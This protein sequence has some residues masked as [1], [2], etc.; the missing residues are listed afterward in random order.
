MQRLLELD[1]RV[2]RLAL[3]AVPA[4]VLLIGWGQV[5]RPA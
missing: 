3:L 1:P 4:M 2:L 5:L